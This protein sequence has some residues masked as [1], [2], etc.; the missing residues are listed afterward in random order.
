MSSD[1]KGEI[2]E[3]LLQKNAERYQRA[4]Q[5]QYFTPRPLIH[6]MVKCLRPEPKKT[7][8]DP[9]C[10][11]RGIF[12]R[13]AQAFIADPANYSLDREQKEFPENETFTV[14]KL[15]SATYKTALMNLY[16]HQ[17]RRYLRKCAGLLSVMHYSLDPRYRVDYVLTNPLHSE[18]VCTY[19]QMK[20]RARGKKTWFIT[21]RISGQPVPISN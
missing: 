21:G 12:P 2:Y 4:A 3:G 8:A 19:L 18:K 7:I 15:V 1:V 17:H 5:G 16:L 14:M 10:G 20:R 6:A 11:S 9:C 13:V